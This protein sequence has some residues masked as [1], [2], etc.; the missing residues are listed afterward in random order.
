MKIV[1]AMPYQECDSCKKCVLDVYKHE[2][3]IFVDC[4]KK[5][6]CLDDDM[7]GETKHED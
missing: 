7:K 4:K 5:E 3:V 1:N 6:K 2:N